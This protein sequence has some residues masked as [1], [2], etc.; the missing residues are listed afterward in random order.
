MEAVGMDVYKTVTKAGWYI[1]P[2]GDNTSLNDIPI[3][4]RVGIVLID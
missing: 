1:Y 3:G 2:V 4:L